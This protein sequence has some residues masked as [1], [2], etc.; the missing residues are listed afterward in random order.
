MVPAL[1]LTSRAHARRPS[2]SRSRS[3]SPSR[4]PELEQDP[5]TVVDPVRATAVLED[6]LDHLGAAHHRPFSREG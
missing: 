1:V 6:T 3:P 5:V 2:P 4:E